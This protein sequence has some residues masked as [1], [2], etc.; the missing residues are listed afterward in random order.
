MIQRNKNSNQN[1]LPLPQPVGVTQSG[2]LGEPVLHTHT[3]AP[4]SFRG[5]KEQWTFGS[6]K[7][8]YLIG[9]SNLSRIPP[10]PHGNVQVDS[11]S[12]ATTYHFLQAM[13]R[14]PPHPH[15]RHLIISI[16]LNNRELNPEKNTNKQLNLLYQTA[17]TVFPNAQI[18]VPLI[19]FSPNLPPTQ[20]ANLTKVNSFITSHY[21]TLSHIPAQQFFTQ[22]DGIHWTQETAR[23]IFTH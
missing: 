2:D 13:Q 21:S 14:T 1:E 4:R 3:Q 16:G 19:H 22:G 23:R 18:H 12:G 11:F 17:C 6:E 15:V 9:T 8:I 7:E 20:Q 10:H 5:N